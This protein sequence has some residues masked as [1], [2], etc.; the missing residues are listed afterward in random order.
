MPR[1]QTKKSMKKKG[2]T[3]LPSKRSTAAAS[4][5]HAIHQIKRIDSGTVYKRNP[6][7]KGQTDADQ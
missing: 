2:L 5:R 1:S 4:L 6:K 3:N 7:H